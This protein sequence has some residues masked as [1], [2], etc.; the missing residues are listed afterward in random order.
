MAENKKS[1][2][3]YTDLIHTVKKL[4]NE[5]AGTLLK[6]L[7]SY[8]N[9]ENPVT[10][11]IVIEIAFEPIKQQLKRDLKHWEVIKLKKSEGG[12]KAMEKRWAEKPT[13]EQTKEHVLFNP[14][15]SIDQWFIDLNN[16]NEI[17]EISRLTK[18]PLDFLKSKIEP[19]KKAA[20]LTYPTYGKFTNHFKNWVVKNKDIIATTTRA[21][22]LT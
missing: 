14:H 22:K 17:I 9:D 8:V 2:V 4:N 5:Q 1:F 20:E 16:G 7:L 13:E 6:H 12:K 21:N 11:D 3:L 18:L 10:S 15:K 19:F